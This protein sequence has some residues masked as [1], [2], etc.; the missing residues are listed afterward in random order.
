MSAAEQEFQRLVRASLAA[1]ESDLTR[2]LASLIWHK[3][4]DEVVALDFEVFSDGFTS[5]FPV[6]VFFLDRENTEFLSGWTER[7]SIQVPS[8]PGHPR[9]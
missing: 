5:G 7:R 8:I 1:L 2:V 4:P 3:Y 6:R 9:D